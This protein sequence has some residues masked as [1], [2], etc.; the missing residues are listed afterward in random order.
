MQSA[1]RLPIS[2]SRL[3]T[4]D[5]KRVL[6]ILGSTGSHHV[7]LALAKLLIPDFASPGIATIR[8]GR[9]RNR[10]AITLT[11]NQNRPYDPCRFVGKRNRD[12]ARRPPRKERVDPLGAGGIVAAGVAYDRCRADDEERA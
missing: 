9:R 11:A 7:I 6:P 1:D 3:E 5:S 4:H 10:S 8:S 12:E 2:F